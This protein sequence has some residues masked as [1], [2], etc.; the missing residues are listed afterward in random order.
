MSR[1]MNINLP[2]AKVQTACDKAKI[3]VSAIETLPSG[4]TRLV[5]TREE[6]AE[7]MRV[8]FRTHI[9]EGNVKR[10]AFQR[11]QNSQYG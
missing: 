6:G 11:S 9:I 10:Y 7:E 3:S 4:G 8:V 5:C 2:E 1:A